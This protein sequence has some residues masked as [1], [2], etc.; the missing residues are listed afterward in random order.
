MKQINL[1]GLKM[2]NKLLNSEYDKVD[3]ELIIIKLKEILAYLI[4]KKQEGKL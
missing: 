2:E 1:M 3:P 4:K